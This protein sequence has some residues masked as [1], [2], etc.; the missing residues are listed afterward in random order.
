[1][2]IESTP[3]IYQGV[4]YFVAYI[5]TTAAD[6]KMYLG[7]V[8]ITS[9][10]DVYGPPAEITF[11]DKLN[12]TVSASQ[13]TIQR[14]GLLV[15]NNKLYVGFANFR[16]DNVSYTGP[17][18]FIYR[19]SLTNLSQPEFKFQTSVGN[20]AGIWQAGRGLA[21]DET[22]NVYATTADGLFDGGIANFG[23][24]VLKVSP[25]LAV[26]S[27]F[28]PGNW[29]NLRRQDLDVSSGGPVLVPGTN[30]LIAGGKQGALYL[31]NRSNLGGLQV[32]SS[33]GPVQQFQATHGCYASNPSSGDCGQTLSMAYWDLGPNSMLYVWDRT[34]RLR[35]FTFNG[36]RIDTT[37]A[38]LSAL[39]HLDIGGLSVSSNGAI[40]SSGIVWA[41]TAEAYQGVTAITNIVPGVFRA[42]AAAAANGQPE[43]TEIYNSSMCHGDFMGNFTKFSNPVVADGKVYVIT[44]SNMLR[45]YG[46]LKEPRACK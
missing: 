11:I 5:G 37:P 18:G 22:G 28:T 1:M 19:Y 15:A 4:L 43:L 30:L 21:A 2:G 42:F 16:N 41:M 34:D 46:L 26:S 32:R 45:V 10:K 39:P 36:A 24:S 23:N 13:Y 33:G 44:Q 12:N 27:F 29:Y 17:E 3:V 25:E 31:L 35:A 20:N 9:G 7:A 38:A 14:T 8:D 6:W 40:P